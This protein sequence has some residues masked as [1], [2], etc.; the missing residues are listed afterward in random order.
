MMNFESHIL[1]IL[2]DGLLAFFVGVG[3]AL[4]FNAPKKA[5]LMAGV[6]GAL[7]HMLRYILKDECGAGI[8][9]STLAASLLIG[10]SSIVAAHIVH[11]PP[12]VFSM[13]AC[14]T[15]IP[16]LYAYR[17]MLGVAKIT[18][19][20]LMTKTPDLLTE[21]VH[22]FVLTGSLLFALAIGISVGSLLFRKKSVKNIRL[23]K[24]RKTA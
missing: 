15:M 8:V 6:L 23:I 20:D 5:V 13:P 22:N 19:R 24:N 7:G 12:V 18:D 11:T 2:K 3:F 4:L 14:I 21:T 9:L 17:T 10:F 16:G 1:L